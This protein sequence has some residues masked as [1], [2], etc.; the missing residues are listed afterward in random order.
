[1]EYEEC[2]NL[3]PKVDLNGFGMPE[4]TE[5]YHQVLQKN[6]KRLSPRQLQLKGI[7]DFFRKIW[8]LDSVM[9]PA[10]KAIIKFTQEY[11]EKYNN[12]SCP[13]LNHVHPNLSTFADM[14]ISTTNS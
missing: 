8:N 2:I 13:L 6:E 9:S 14:I 4:M 11:R 7:G 5:S 12:L 10:I 3:V 1:R